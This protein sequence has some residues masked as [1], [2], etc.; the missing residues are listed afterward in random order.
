MA[1]RTVPLLLALLL[2]ATSIAHAQSPVQFSCLDDFAGLIDGN[3]V[4][5]EPSNV[6]LDTNCTIRNYPGGMSTNFSFDNNDLTPYLIIFDNVVHTGQMS[7]NAVAGHKIWFANSSTTGVHPSCQN[8]FIPVEKIDKRNPDPYASIGVP[9]TYRL[10]IPVLFDPLTGAVIDH[11]G[12]V[13]DLHGIIVTDDL[14]ATGAALT[15]VSH[16][17]RWEDDGTDVPHSFS[18]QGGLLTFSG[19]PIVPADRQVIIDLTVVLDDVPANAPGTQ[20][21]NTAKWERSEEHTSELQSPI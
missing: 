4:Q 13:N 5:P 17:V 20:F 6:K 11:D 15:Y 2:G 8:A 1:R 12:S 19:F 10:T 21:V 3:V 9:F 16:T 18:N 7:C 14:N